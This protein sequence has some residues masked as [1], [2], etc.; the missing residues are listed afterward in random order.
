M[1]NFNLAGSAGGIL[2]AVEPKKGFPWEG[3]FVQSP[4]FTSIP[5]QGPETSV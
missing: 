5:Q 4:E 3:T 1:R 2:D